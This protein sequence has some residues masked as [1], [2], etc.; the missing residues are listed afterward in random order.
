MSGSFEYPQY[1]HL[2]HEKFFK[3]IW[4]KSLKIFEVKICFVVV[5]ILYGYCRVLDEVLTLNVSKTSYALS[6][7]VLHMI[8][9]KKVNWQNNFSCAKKK[10]F[11]GRAVEGSFLSK[12][13]PKKGCLPYLIAIIRKETSDMWKIVVILIRY[14]KNPSFGPALDK[15]KP[16]TTRPKKWLYFRTSLTYFVSWFFLASYIRSGFLKFSFVGFFDDI[17]F[18]TMSKYL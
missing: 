11:F 16:S 14:D 12:A 1:H 13:G 6:K 5:T 4:K 10:P 7:H 8:L 17:W 15:N 2:T 3:T 18:S 9:K